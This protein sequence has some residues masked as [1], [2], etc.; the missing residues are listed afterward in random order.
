M[1]DFEFIASDVLLVS[2][3]GSSTIQKTVYQCFC[4]LMVAVTH[5]AVLDDMIDIFIDD[6][7]NCI[8]F[9]ILLYFRDKKQI[10]NFI[11]SVFIY[12]D[13]D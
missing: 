1:I 10:N 8:S 13:M 11:N 12:G 5:N 4:I 2:Y 7:K 9:S 6:S 3:D